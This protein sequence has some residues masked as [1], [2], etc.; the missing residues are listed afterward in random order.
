[1]TALAFSPDARR[2]AISDHRGARVWDVERRTFLTPRLPH[3]KPVETIR[4]DR[5]G[6][7]LVTVAGDGMARMFAA[8]GDSV[9]P[10]YPPVPQ[11][12]GN[13]GVSH[14]GADAVAPRF[15]DGD[16]V[17]LTVRRWDNTTGATTSSGW[18]R[19]RGPSCTRASPPGTVERLTS[20][21]VDPEGKTVAAFWNSVGRIFRVP[22]GD[23]A[24]VIPREEVRGSRTPSSRP[25]ATNSR[26]SG[27]ILW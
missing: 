10:L 27:T 4:F 2:L 7:R 5:A 20:L 19:R 3:P 24:A 11:S 22:K 12:L 25:R 9:E 15:V 26:P 8:A 23:L 6:R 14:G 21:S 18:T 13:F 17:L 1:M 16:R